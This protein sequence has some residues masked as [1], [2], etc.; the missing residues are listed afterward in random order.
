MAPEEHVGNG[1]WPHTNISS[2]AFGFISRSVQ[3]EN[4]RSRTVSIAW[5]V[6]LR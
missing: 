2:M 6:G 1:S 3:R 5:I 4:G